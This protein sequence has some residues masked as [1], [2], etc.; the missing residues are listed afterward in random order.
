MREAEWEK[1][2]RGIYLGEWQFVWRRDIC[3]L[4]SA[5]TSSWGW[6]CWPVKIWVGCQQYTLQSIQIHCL[7]VLSSLH[8]DTA[9]PGFRLVTISGKTCKRKASRTN[10]SSYRCSQSRALTHTRHL[11]HCPIQFPLHCPLNV[12]ENSV[13]KPPVSGSLLSLMLFLTK[14]SMFL[15]F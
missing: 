7:F 14:D 4:S 6:V 15:M 5:G 8:P 9:S 3:E 1:G 10:C 12:G 2:K 13:I 11:L